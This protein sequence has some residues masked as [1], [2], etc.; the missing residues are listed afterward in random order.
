MEKTCKIVKDYCG[1][2]EDIRLG[3]DQ[4]VFDVVLDVILRPGTRIEL[5]EWGTLYTSSIHEVYEEDEGFRHYCELLSGDNSDYISSD[6]II[7]GT[8]CTYEEEEYQDVKYDFVVWKNKEIKSSMEYSKTAPRV[9]EGDIVVLADGL[10][11]LVREIRNGIPYG[12]TLNNE[13]LPSGPYANGAIGQICCKYR[14]VELSDAWKLPDGTPFRDYVAGVDSISDE[15]PDSITYTRKMSVEDILKKYGDNL[16]NYQRELLAN[17]VLQDSTLETLSKKGFVEGLLYGGS[18][19]YFD[20]KSPQAKGR[21]FR[22]GSDLPHTPRRS[23]LISKVSTPTKRVVYQPWGSYSPTKDGFF[24]PPNREPYD[25]NC[26]TFSGH[27]SDFVNLRK[28]DTLY[29]ILMN[30]RE[31]FITSNS[32]FP[33]DAIQARIEE[34]EEYS[35]PLLEEVIA[36]AEKEENKTVYQDK[37]RDSFVKCGMALDLFMSGHKGFIAG[38]CFKNI[39]LGQKI[40]D[41]DIF[42]ENMEDWSQA[43]NHY[44]NNAD[45][46]FVYHNANAC[47][48]KYIKTG[49]KVEII[50][51]RFGK[52]EDLIREFDFTVAK[53]AYY[54]DTSN[55]ITEY[56]FVYHPDFFEHLVM[57]KLV[58]DES[59]TFPVN[60]FERTYRYQKYGFSM[61]RETKQ[62]LIKLLQGANVDD[63]GSSLYFGFD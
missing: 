8:T 27:T 39:F 30:E 20:A 2:Q 18:S 48:F 50:K 32:P 31:N 49:Q 26:V 52:P 21:H 5:G 3:I 63:I 15:I 59:C 10:K 4:T 29:N 13:M 11:L 1:P 41:V 34:I 61:C 24:I 42:F 43:F 46:K 58:M 55:D 14:K 9:C 57:K 17:R 60:T 6:Y 36:L 33:I 12:C 40:K 19:S 51:S 54:K 62:K 47:C 28:D 37:D 16:T 44:T 38:G 45:F 22:D 23:K 56:R 7:E 53:F 35:S 25:P